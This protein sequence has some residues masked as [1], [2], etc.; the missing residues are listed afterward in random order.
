MASRFWDEA[1]A[2]KC[3]QHRYDFPQRRLAGRTIIVAGGT[4][5]L[6][7]ATCALLAQEGARIVAGFRANR[8]RAEAFS[9]A[10]REQYGAAL[11]LVS[12]DIMDPGVRRTMLEA[13]LASAEPFAGAAVFPGDPA[14]AAL[15]SLNEQAVAASLA[16]NFTGPLLLAKEIGG[17]LEAGEG[18]SIVLLSTMQAVGVFPAS[19]NYAAPKAALLHAARVLA[20][21]WKRVRVNVVAP[22]ATISGMAE[23]SVSSGKYDS[24]IE[25]GAIARFGRPEDVARAVRFFLEPDSYVTGQVLVVDG[26][27][28]L[29]K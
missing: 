6:G 4:G 12:G 23:A 27:L 9:N 1:A 20:A 10:M 14:R 17:A 22:G 25:R 13:A 26:G 3:R 5:G 15:E 19:V 24:F 11:T 8:A 2:E 16:A 7:A 29:R 21:T 18:G 28:T